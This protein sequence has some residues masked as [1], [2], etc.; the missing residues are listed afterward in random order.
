MNRILEVCLAG[1]SVVV[2]VAAANTAAAQTLQKGISVGMAVTKNA[3]PMPE[4]DS[5][6][7][8]IVTITAK[9]DLFFGL[10]SVTPEGLLEAMRSRPRNRLAKL[11]IKADA[12]A[13]FAD[14]EKALQ[15][16]PTVGFEEPVLL[17][18]QP[19]QAAPGTIVPPN[20]LEV[21]VAP[22]SSE[23]IMVHVLDTGVSKPAVRVNGADVSV[24]VLRNT[25]GRMLQ[26]RKERLVVVKAA[27]TLRFAQVAEVID[28]CRGA[29]ARVGVGGPEL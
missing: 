28:A 10:E 27:G 25:L 17:T 3:A 14:V 19:E 24:D 23:A 16:G 26:T 5:P 18:S 11:Y 8:W 12:G 21:L 13:L 6:D 20:G 22:S 1:L 9:G 7:A 4:A 2:S 29:G 15:A